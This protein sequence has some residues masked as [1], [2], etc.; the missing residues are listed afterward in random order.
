MYGQEFGIFVHHQ[1]EI[2]V[3]VD[4]SSLQWEGVE[5]VYYHCYISQCLI[6]FRIML[7]KNELMAF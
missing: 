5:T 4:I 3:D 1:S 7:R 6:Y 2:V